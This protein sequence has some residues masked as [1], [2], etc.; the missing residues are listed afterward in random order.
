MG[1]LLEVWET[2]ASMKNWLRTRRG[3]EVKENPG[4]L[5]IPVAAFGLLLVVCGIIAEVT[6]E[7]LASKADVRL[8]EHESA[9][10]SNAETIAA[11]ARK[12]AEAFQSQI[13]DASARVKE[14]EAKIASAEALS[15]DASARVATADA[16]IAEA[17]EK[18]AEAN[19]SAEA[20][21]I[22]R[23][24]LEAQIAPRRLTN[25]E[26]S[27]IL[28]ACNGCTGRSVTIRSYATDL[29]SAIL[30]KQLV[31][32]FGAAGMRVQDATASNSP[33]GGFLI[34]INVTGDNRLASEVR[35][36]LSDK[37]RLAVVPTA[38]TA[39][40]MVMMGI[41]TFPTDIEITVGVKPI[42]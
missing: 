33:V 37:G 39:A 11:Q 28:K 38:L 42:E 8:R 1:C 17:Q 40:P 7:G 4:S 35:S 26:V 20:E 12:E 32:L 13:V 10:L 31:A 41:G 2:A 16:R 21:R 34:G 22:E 18:A 23:L 9:I 29:E 6:F 24:K 36:L 5:A 25:Q 27:E 3:L 14:A 30:A 19:K 15:K